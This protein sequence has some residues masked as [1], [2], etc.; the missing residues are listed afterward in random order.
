MVQLVYF[1]ALASC[2]SRGELN[3][4][5]TQAISNVLS[6]PFNLFSQLII[7]SKIDQSAQLP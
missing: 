2:L 4:F 6:V 3:R 1:R 5:E 7:L